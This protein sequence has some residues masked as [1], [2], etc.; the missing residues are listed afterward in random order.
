MFLRDGTETLRKTKYA[1]FTLTTVA[2]ALHVV[3]EVVNYKGES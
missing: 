2:T 1:T 3:E